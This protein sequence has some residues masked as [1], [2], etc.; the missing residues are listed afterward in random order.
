MELEI[1]LEEPGE[2]HAVIRYL[3]LTFSVSVPAVDPR[4]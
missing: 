3:L 2:F 4:N 1:N